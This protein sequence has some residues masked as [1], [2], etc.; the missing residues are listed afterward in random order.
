MPEYV[1]C[2]YKYI[3]SRQCVYNVHTN[4]LIHERVHTMYIHVYA[5]MNMY[6][7]VQT[8][9]YH[10]QTRTYCFAISCPGG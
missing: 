8:C 5:F 9:L 3:N 1:Q 4:V 7:Y 6:K 2:T 10:V